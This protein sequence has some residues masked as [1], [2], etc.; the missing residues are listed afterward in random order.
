M[1]P[2]AHADVFEIPCG[3]V[4][5]LIAAINTA[6]AKR[7]NDVIKLSACTYTLTA[8]DND[9]DGPNGLP[10]ITSRIK[11]KGAGATQ[12]IIARA[13]A[14]APFRLM[15][16]AESGSLALQDVGLALGLLSS[17][18]G[19]GLFNAGSLTVTSSSVEGNSV[20]DLNDC[21]FCGTGP[22]GGIAN[23]G[24][25]ILVNTMVID[26]FASFG[27]G[28]FNDGVLKMTGSTVAQNRTDDSSGAGTC[29]GIASSGTAM[30]KSSTISGN[31]GSVLGGG[32]CN[33]GTATLRHSSVTEN[34]VPDGD[35]G[36]VV[37]DGTFSMRNSIVVGN[38]SCVEGAP[39]GFCPVS[40]DCLD[41][42][43]MVSLGRNQLGTGC[44]SNRRDI[45][46]SADQV[47]VTALASLHGNGS[48]ML[49]Q[50]PLP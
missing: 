22:G 40:D 45:V 24:K 15:H 30:I 5:A 7:Q 41:N 17:G 39:P 37:N 42:G 31:R 2:G 21:S 38:T 46:V 35:G 47:F 49:A 6:N 28:I 50:L 25:L 16:V 23:T 12:T 26:N 27:G 29:G 9:T 33:S 36:G 18:S 34:S 19:G 4:P 3:D 43:E 1:Q 48:P 10:S 14:S 11:I 13:A 32:I 44:P 8:V 20:V